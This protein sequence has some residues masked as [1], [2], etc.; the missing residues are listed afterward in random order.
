[1]HMQSLSFSLHQLVGSIGPIP[2]Q[3]NAKGG[4]PISLGAFRFGLLKK[5]VLKTFSDFLLERLRYLGSLEFKDTTLGFNF[6]LLVFHWMAFRLS[7]E[8]GYHLNHLCTH[9]GRCTYMDTHKHTEYEDLCRKL[10]ICFYVSISWFWT[11]KK[12]STFFQY[13]PGQ[14]RFLRD[15]NQSSDQVLY[16]CDNETEGIPW[17]S[18]QWVHVRGTFLCLLLTKFLS[19]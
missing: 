3:S 6:C 11:G 13:F 4:S 12:R 16:W 2:N 8:S 17:V 5:Q 14:N 18:L 10:S 15:P 1:M 7:S 19:S 9:P